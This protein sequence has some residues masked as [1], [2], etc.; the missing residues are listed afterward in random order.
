MPLTSHNQ[1]LN[2]LLID[3]GRSLLQY[4]GECWPWTSATSSAQGALEKLVRKQQAGVGKLFD[5]LNRRGHVVDFGA[6]P[7]EYTD[8]HY[9]ALSFLLGQLIA[10]AKGLVDEIAALQVRCSG[11]AEATAI[12]GDLASSQAAI[13]SE[14]KS[15]AGSTASGAAA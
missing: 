13:L 11:D 6:F 3:L 10:D 1:E 14:L 4:V 12:L 7:T 8:L 2:R 9:C 15:L 5:L